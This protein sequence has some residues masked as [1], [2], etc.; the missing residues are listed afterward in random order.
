M[1]ISRANKL[2]VELIM[3]LYI[4]LVREEHRVG[5]IAKWERPTLKEDEAH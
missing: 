5:L 1:I 2:L 3:K 4:R